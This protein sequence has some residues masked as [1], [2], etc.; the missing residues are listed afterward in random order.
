[1]PALSSPAMRVLFFGGT[2]F[3][4]RHAVAACLARGH[5]VTIVCRGL[6][7]PGAF[8][9]VARITGERTDPRCLAQLGGRSFDAVIDSCAYL[10]REGDSDP[11]VPWLLR[12][13][14]EGGEIAAPG[15]PDGPVQLVDAR[16]LAAFL[17][18]CAE[19]RTPGVF[20]AVSPPLP[21]REL[22]DA[23]RTATRSDARFTWI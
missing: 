18:D 3:V 17:V 14:A 4:G 15:D 21:A 11:R 1:M 10:P 5:E 19:R 23:A 12:R 20:N 2:G 7:D 9:G 13:I 6:S 8:P 16:D 22:Y